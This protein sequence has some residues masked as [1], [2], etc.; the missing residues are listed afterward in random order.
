MAA[1]QH[2]IFIVVSIYLTI[3]IVFE[4]SL[5]IANYPNDLFIR[6]RAQSVNGDIRFDD[7][8]YYYCQFDQ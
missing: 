2:T 3:F 1:D 4:L 8:D 5:S 7:D 6:Y